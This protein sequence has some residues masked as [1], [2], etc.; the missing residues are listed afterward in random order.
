[1]T[2]VCQE[3]TLGLGSG[4]RNDSG[5]LGIHSQSSLGY[6]DDGAFQMGFALL[7]VKYKL[8]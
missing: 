8:G 5:L 6:V 3:L 2:H 4:L 1:M 7:F